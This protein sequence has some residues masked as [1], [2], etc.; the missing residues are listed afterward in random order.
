MLHSGKLVSAFRC[1]SCDCV[2]S[3]TSVDDDVQ[4]Q[5]RK[6]VTSAKR[7]TYHLLKGQPIEFTGQEIIDFAKEQKRELLL[8]DRIYKRYVEIEGTAY[9]ARHLVVAFLKIKYP[10]IPANK[11]QS[12]DVTRLLKGGGFT[13]MERR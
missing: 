7:K 8:R 1:P 11:V 4:T 5:L 9:S 12:N 10:D 2:L 6:L 3:L 13:V